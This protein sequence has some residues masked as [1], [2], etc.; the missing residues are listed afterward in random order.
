MKRMIIVLIL[1]SIINASQYVPVLVGGE[2]DYD[3]CGYGKVKG[4]KKDGD[5]FLTVRSTPSTKG[6]ALDRLHN[7]DGVWMCDKEGK[8]IGIIYGDNCGL[9]SPIA[10]QKAYDGSCKSGWVYEKWVILIAG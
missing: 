3:P 9:S 5:G 8:W 10:K 2:I 1:T 7:E 4:L 6:A